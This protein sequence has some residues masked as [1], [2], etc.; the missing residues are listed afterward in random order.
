[1]LDRWGV[2]SRALSL[3]A[4]R[5]EET[6]NKLKT[7]KQVY[8]VTEATAKKFKL[9]SLLS[10][11]GF[12]VGLVCFLVGIGKGSEGAAT[13]GFGIVLGGVSVIAYIVNKVRVW[14]YHR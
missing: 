14:W 10:I 1:M 7:E 2:L 6:M 11:L 3:N 4:N 5:E 13:G 9:V 12:L 8:V